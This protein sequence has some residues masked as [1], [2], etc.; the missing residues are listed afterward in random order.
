MSGPSA[1]TYHADRANKYLR[2]CRIV[3]D[4]L[5]DKV[6]GHTDDGNEADGLQN[7][8]YLEGDTEDSVVSHFLGCGGIFVARKKDMGISLIEG[9]GGVERF[10]MCEERAKGRKAIGKD[11]LLVVR[12]YIL[13]VKRKRN[14]RDK[15]KRLSSQKNNALL[16][17]RVRLD[18]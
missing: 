3:L 5:G 11:R 12:F 2:R 10:R 1:C 13:G 15:D 8:V 6:R 4:H 16:S 14:K 18:V 9:V 7:P 17:K